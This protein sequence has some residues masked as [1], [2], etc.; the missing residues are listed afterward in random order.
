MTIPAMAPPLRLDP[1]SLELFLLESDTAVGV[2]VCTTDVVV[3]IIVVGAWLDADTMDLVM[4]WVVYSMEVITDVR[5]LFEDEDFSLS[6]LLEEEDFS[7]LLELALLLEDGEV[8]ELEEEVELESELE[9]ELELE[10]DDEL[11]WDEEE[12]VELV[13][14][15]VELDDALVEELILVLEDSA[16]SV[17]TAAT[18]P[19]TSIALEPPQVSP[20]QP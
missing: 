10:L 20:G 7:E 2:V 18:L 12:E 9:R 16:D 15:E 11:F 14:V 6:L 17:N 3:T 1:L 4:I 8:D 19:Y 5:A 13:C